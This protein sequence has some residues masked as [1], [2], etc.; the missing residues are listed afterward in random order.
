MLVYTR[1][2]NESIMVG[3]EVKITV[4]DIGR[5]RVR[6]GIEADKDIPVHRIEVYNKL[7]D[8]ARQVV[9]G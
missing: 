8:N 7:K 4:I 9:D 6:I 1:K 2:L 5:G 3:D